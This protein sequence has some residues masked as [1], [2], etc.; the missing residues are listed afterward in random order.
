MKTKFVR[1]FGEFKH[2]W[3]LRPIC[4]IFKHEKEWTSIYGIRYKQCSRCG[5]DFFSD[6]VKDEQRK[7]Q[8]R[9][10][11]GEIGEL[12]GIRFYQTNEEK[13]K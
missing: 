3:W 11:S 8:N 7:F 10:Y 2:R 4:W 9:Y 6:E 13:N 5:K 1:V 12:Y